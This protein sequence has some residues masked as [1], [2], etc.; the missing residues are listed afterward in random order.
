MKG[1]QA[2]DI[3]PRLGLTGDYFPVGVFSSDKEMSLPCL[4]LSTNGTVNVVTMFLC[5]KFVS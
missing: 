5:S 2:P 4:Y 1:I 3:D